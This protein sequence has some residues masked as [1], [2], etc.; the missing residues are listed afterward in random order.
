M[1]ST[2]KER[3]WL[4]F[5]VALLYV[6]PIVGYP[7]V[8]VLPTIFG[9]NSRIVSIPYRAAALGLC[10]GMLGYAV[11]AG[12]KLYLGW[13]WIPTILL[14][15][16]YTVRI[17][18]EFSGD[19]MSSL[20]ESLQWELGVVMI[21]MLALAM[22]PSRRSLWW[23]QLLIMFIGIV[24]CVLVSR[25]GAEPD[26]V[27]GVTRASF[28]ALNTMNLARASSAVAVVSLSV[29]LFPVRPNPGI[30]IRIA[31]WCITV[32]SCHITVATASRGPLFSLMLTLPVMVI[33]AFRRKTSLK[34][35][36]IALAFGIATLGYAFY[37]LPG[38]SLQDKLQEL[39]VVRRIESHDVT[40]EWRAHAFVDAFYQFL[41]SPIIGSS[42]FLRYTGEACHN[43][44]LE[45]LTATG[46][47]GG[48]PLL[49][50][51]AGA[52]RSCWIIFRDRPW[53]VWTTL[54]FLIF[55]I[56]SIF[57]S[58][59]FAN[60]QIYAYIFAVAAIAYAPKGFY[61]EEE[62]IPVSTLRRDRKPSPNI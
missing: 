14:W 54:I 6:L 57:S 40:N 17:L 4:T 39:V 10:L 44:Y 45:C 59:M 3:K 58:S 2:T 53:A 46:I 34:M 60:N 36:T 50:L 61:G 43:M 9:I 35:L 1:T 19:A 29:I 26:Q 38:S 55:F 41:D 48:I 51:V 11:V 7:A 31:A 22:T 25:F 52:F 27:T 21:P 62:N 32:V 13:L 23:A 42:Y 18:D 12:R 16:A 33:L 8:S 15:I 28:Y 24:P 30:I 56:G 5:A 49:L 20:S 37:K 47:F